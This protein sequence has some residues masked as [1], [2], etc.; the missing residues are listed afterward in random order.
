MRTIVRVTQMDGH[1]ETRRQIL[2]TIREVAVVSNR[3]LI[4]LRR[5]EKM[6]LTLDRVGL[7]KMLVKTRETK[8]QSRLGE[9]RLYSRYR[10]LTLVKAHHRSNRVDDLSDRREMNQEWI[11]H[12]GVQSRPRVTRLALSRLS[13]MN[14]ARDRRDRFVL[15]TTASRHRGTSRA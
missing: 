6:V 5:L 3:R 15:T 14:R 2:T 9:G 8:V 10:E 4:H 1:G 7:R 12:N 13:E 11:R